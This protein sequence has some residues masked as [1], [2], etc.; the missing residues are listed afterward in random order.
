MT[1]R[2]IAYVQQLGFNPP[3]PD[4]MKQRPRPSNEPIMTTWLIIRYCLTG[5]Y[6]GIA[7]VGIFV[8]HYL[9]QGIKLSELS[10]WGKCD[11]SW[12]PKGTSCR[13][14][15]TGHGRM[16]PQ[17]LSL[18]TLVCMEML[19][20][21]SAVS[22][23]NSLLSVGPHRNPLLLLGVAFP[24]MLHLLVVYSSRFGLNSLGES[25][26]LVALTRHDWI[27]ILKW[28]L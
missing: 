23:D 12:T 19:K 18:T 4:L 5:L 27:T 21:L 17:T 6:V 24:M 2:L 13:A 1:E 28:S 16:H 15:F 14:L 25:F 26:G 7:T 22:V 10:S 8:N 9:S 20:A 3:V 11:A